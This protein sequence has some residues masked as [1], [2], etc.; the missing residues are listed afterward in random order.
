M[1]GCPRFGVSRGNAVHGVVADVSEVFGGGHRC[2]W[3]TCWQS[4]KVSSGK[5]LVLYQASAN[6][7][8][9]DG[10]VRVKLSL[11]TGDVT[12]SPAIVPA[13]HRL[14]VQVCPC[15]PRVCLPSGKGATI[16]HHC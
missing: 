10:D 14:F 12:L 15:L 9:E 5:K 1:W 6:K 4:E 16:A 13:G 11:G 8:L 2:G 7:V 3:G